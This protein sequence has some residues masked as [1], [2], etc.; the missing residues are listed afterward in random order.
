MKPKTDHMKQL[1]SC[2]IK[3]VEWSKEDGCFVGKCPE[4]FFGGVH[5]DHEADV[6]RQ[7]CEAVEDTLTSRIRHGDQLPQPALAQKYSGRFVL[8]LPAD[9]HKALAI[10]AFREGMSLNDLCL[11]SIQKAPGTLL[12]ATAMSSHKTH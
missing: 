2:Y 7:L 1:A 8:R 5:G 11:R 4:L 12:P 9:L 3:T 6:Y 10:R